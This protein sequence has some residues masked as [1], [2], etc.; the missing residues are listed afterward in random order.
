MAEHKNSPFFKDIFSPLQVQRLGESRVLDH[1]SNLVIQTDG[2]G[3]IIA[4]SR[5]L[6]SVIEMREEDLVGF[7]LDKILKPEMI[8]VVEETLEQLHLFNEEVSEPIFLELIHRQG[9]PIKINFRIMPVA[10]GE[11]SGA[12]LISEELRDDVL[13][14]EE[15]IHLQGM[16]SIGEM[17]GEIGHEL[18][19]FLLVTVGRAQLIGPH[20]RRNEREKVKN[21]V[22]LI[23]DQVNKM[24]KLVEGLLDV[25]RAGVLNEPIDLNDVLLKTIQFVLP[26]NKYDNIKFIPKLAPH[27]PPVAVNVGRIQQVLIN[28]FNNSADAMGKRKG[29]GGEIIIETLSDKEEYA[30]EI[31]ISDTGPGVPAR[32]IDRLFE[33]RFTTRR[34]GNGL[35]LY[36][37]RK[38]ITEHNG[39]IELKNSKTRGFGA[40]CAIRLNGYD[41]K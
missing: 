6:C 29:E 30:V 4:V 39:V 34:N 25:T 33:P 41:R 5:K 31:K 19:N 16:A 27:L 2:S 10:Q 20:I 37:S 32:F 7:A 24:K 28:L 9:I 14:D 26:Q 13:L 15:L 1:C 21:D 23:I 22:D 18:N 3:E 38:I 17:A 12:L 36:I 11:E 35:G 40:V 8:A